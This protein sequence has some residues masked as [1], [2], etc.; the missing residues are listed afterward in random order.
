MLPDKGGSPNDIG[1]SDSHRLG[2]DN[3]LFID[4]RKKRDGSADRA[5][6]KCQRNGRKIL[7]NARNSMV[8]VKEGIA[9]PTKYSFGLAGAFAKSLPQCWRRALLAAAR[10]KKG[11][12]ERVSSAKMEMPIIERGWQQTNLLECFRCQTESKIKI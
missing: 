9:F 11:V 1:S 7:W 10:K 5:S 8:Q 6:V 4:T 2:N 3:A 12:E